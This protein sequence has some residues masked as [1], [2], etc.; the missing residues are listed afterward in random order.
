MKNRKLVSTLLIALVFFICS[1]TAFAEDVMVPKIEPFRIIEVTDAETTD[2]ITRIDVA[3]QATDSDAEENDG[4]IIIREEVDVESK[5][6]VES[7]IV[8][9]TNYASIVQG[10]SEKAVIVD[11]ADAYTDI[12]T[13]GS[14]K[15]IAVGAVGAF[16]A[17]CSALIGV[18]ITKKRAQ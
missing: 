5:E 9:D 15:V 13:T 11:Y 4:A 10:E 8:I 16:A 1:A 17:V 18:I 7:E 14:S 3:V 2:I 12:P 6:P